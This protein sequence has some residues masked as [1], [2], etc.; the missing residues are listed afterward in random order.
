MEYSLGVL[1]KNKDYYKP[2]KPE[3]YI[4]EFSAVK[5]KWIFHWLSEYLLVMGGGGGVVTD[6]HGAEQENPV[7]T[8]KLVAGLFS[9]PVLHT[10]LLLYEKLVVEA[11]ERDYGRCIPELPAWH[12]VSTGYSGAD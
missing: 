2:Y 8:K 3:R 7:I 6:Y 10:Q 1:L 11:W 4:G 12:G 9:F 5:V